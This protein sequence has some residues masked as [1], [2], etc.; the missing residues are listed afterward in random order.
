MN[1]IIIYFCIYLFYET[2]DIHTKLYN[3]ETN[4]ILILTSIMAQWHVTDAQH[5]IKWIKIYNETL[6]T[7]LHYIQ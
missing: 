6:K 5:E 7:I 3:I 2:Y 1:I 4:H